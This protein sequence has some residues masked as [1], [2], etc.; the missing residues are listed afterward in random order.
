[1]EVLVGDVDLQVVGEVRGALL[2]DGVTTVFGNP[3]HAGGIL[4]IEFGGDYIN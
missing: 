4:S 2:N 3:S 1:M